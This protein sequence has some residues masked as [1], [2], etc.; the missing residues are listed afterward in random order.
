M[1]AQ[2]K[3][4]LA[5]IFSAE[6]LRS[7]LTVWVWAA[8]AGEAGGKGLERNFANFEGVDLKK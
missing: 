4:I 1:T 2:V 6:F 3:E 8:G 5:K 7:V